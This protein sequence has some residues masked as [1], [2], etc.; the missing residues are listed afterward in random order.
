MAFE[1]KMRN[2]VWIFL[3]SFATLILRVSGSNCTSS[4]SLVG[5]KTDF[6]MVQ[7]QLRGSLEILDDC[8]FRV[9]KFDMLA[10][11]DVYWWGSLG[12][13]FENMTNG[14]PV[15]NT[16]L[17]QTYRNDTL[18]VTLQKN[19]T[20]EEFK[21][22]SVWDKPTGSDFGHVLLEYYIP[23]T[24]EYGPPPESGFDG[25]PPEPA[26]APGPASAWAP[27]ANAPSYADEPA[28]APPEVVLSGQKQPTMFD[29]CISLT[30]TFRLRWT[31]NTV[32]GTID[33]GL[34]AALS[35]SQYMAFAW[36]QTGLKKGFMLGADAV[37]AGMDEKGLPFAEDYY[38]GDYA[39]CSWD[40]NSPS[41]VCPDSIFAGGYNMGA[42]NTKLVYGQEVDGIT[43]IRYQRTLQ[44]VDATFDVTINTTS[45]MQVIW[46]MG[47]MKPPDLIKHN[48]T[49]QN[50]GPSYGYRKLN[51][52]ESVDECLGPMVANTPQTDVVVADRGTTIVVGSD[53]AVHYPNPPFPKK[54]LYINQKESPL[55]RVE[56]GVPVDFSIQAGHD[57]AFYITSDPLGGATNASEIIYAGGPEVHGVPVIPYPLT[58]LPNRST[59]DLVYYQ[60]YFT[61]KRGWKMEVVDGGLSDMYN[62]SAPLADN[63]VTLFWTVNSNRIYLAVRG[64]VKSGYLAIAFGSGMVNSFSYVGWV[65]DQGVGHIEAY[66]MDGKS[67]S[68]IHPTGEEL[69]DKKCETRN[70]IVTFEF[71]RPL[72]PS[73][74]KGTLCKNVIDPAT[75]LKVVWALGDAW[76]SDEL[77][78]G[79]MHTDFSS[80]STLISFLLGAAKV[81]QLQPVL[82]VHGF[83]MFI[84]W[85][86]LLPG[87]VLGARYLKHLD[88]NG[89]FEIHMYSQLSA[90]VV[91]LLGLLFAVAELHGF[92]TR[93]AHMKV[94]LASII[95]ACWQ[96]INGYL[97]PSK[98]VPGEPERTQRT[99]WQYVHM[100]T[101][102]SALLL[103]FISLVTGI[104]QLAERDG[105]GT[106]KPLQWALFAWFFA[107]AA[108]VGYV[109]FQGFCS[110]RHQ[111]TVVFDRILGSEEDVQDLSP[112]N[113]SSFFSRD[114]KDS[115]P[116][117]AR[118]ME[119]QLEALH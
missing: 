19:Y 38:L 13:D 95:L 92:N 91:M 29:N 11:T 30:S 80:R 44:G 28:L 59:P 58:W 52:G 116:S 90:L 118:G 117:P 98:S 7:H 24:V 66:W 69:S 21:V 12:E 47:M 84:A 71:S 55:L 4:S 40:T 46:A 93:T 119:I 100:Y 61:Q 25:E 15:S 74:S 106:M 14:F 72:Q 68:S 94:G 115:H 37:V 114:S 87:G 5:L 60:D 76:T 83:M 64:E 50:H 67:A 16:K 27:S 18:E 9:T 89:W 105:V 51:V 96:A 109:E 41:G 35:K 78:D 110:K 70:G 26:P 32:A 81:E 36:A 31:L 73:C 88:S 8:T 103:G 2:S 34:E 20:W 10:G 112:H 75:P 86:L 42:N 107:V 43:L 108:I 79:N 22:L 65:D 63:R 97:R 99:V 54:V 56:R 62:S 85:G 48:R 1:G 53:V 104:S 17:N 33:V 57:I 77:T 39:E 82:A 49:P 102:R 45:S 111:D 101:G 23:E 113:G 6:L 3:V